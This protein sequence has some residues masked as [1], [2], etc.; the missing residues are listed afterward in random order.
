MIVQCPQCSTK[1]KINESRLQ[2]GVK[3]KCTRC[4]HIFVPSLPEDDGIKL[5]E[6]EIDGLGD[7]AP[8][9]EKETGKGREFETEEKEPK[10][11]EIEISPQKKK[12]SKKRS[13]FF[14]VFI[15][16]VFLLIGLGGGI[17]YF[18]PQLI[19][20]IPGLNTIKQTQESLEQKQVV[21]E[22]RVKNISLENVRQ[23]FVTNEKIGQLFVIEGQAVNRFNQP[24]ELIKLRASLYDKQGNVVQSKEFYCGNV[25]SLF[26]LQVLSLE[27]LESALNAKVGILTNNTYIKPGGS[28][29]FMVVFKDPPKGVEEFGLEVIDVKDPP[30]K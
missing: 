27:E 16:L 12:K 9:N 29:P 19:N 28:T 2:P 14:V 25:V 13:R 22:E 8:E 5:D 1:Y 17:Y 4:E 26:R 18:F 23:Y 7:V 21:N 30:K 15:L 6:P 24:K 20:Y 10:D 3:L 11:I